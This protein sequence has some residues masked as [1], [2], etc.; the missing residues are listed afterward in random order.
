MEA[1][2]KP[3][4]KPSPHEIDADY[5]KKAQP[6]IKEQIEKA[7]ARLARSLNENVR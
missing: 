7:G 3:P 1:C 4:T 2:R 6:L 5:V